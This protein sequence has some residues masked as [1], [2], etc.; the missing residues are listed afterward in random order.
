MENETVNVDLKI[1]TAENYKDAD[2][3][4][5]RILE[6]NLTVVGFN[7]KIKEINT[8]KEISKVYISFYNEIEFECV[9]FNIDKILSIDKKLPHSLKR[10]F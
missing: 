3:E 4:A 1:T 8:V 7:I 10:I 5:S 2:R 9:V 6:L